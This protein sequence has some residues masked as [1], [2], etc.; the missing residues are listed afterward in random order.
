MS[1]PQDKFQLEY[2]ARMNVIYHEWRE[3][4]FARCIR[5]TAF[6]SVLLSSA[7]VAALT[8]LLLP[9]EM[10]SAGTVIAIVLSSL[11]AI[12]NAAALAFDW[13]GQVA[14]HA[15]FK[16][17]WTALLVDAGLSEDNDRARFE[18]LVRQLK[19]LNAD[20]PPAIDQLLNKAAAEA[21]KAFGVTKP[22]A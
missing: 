20:E 8:K 22:A 14:A 2:L 10:Q 6:V 9:V 4:H 19:E 5:W 12:G 1:V 7:A 17:K 15:R 16:A 18:S 11:V 21:D 3:R 13:F